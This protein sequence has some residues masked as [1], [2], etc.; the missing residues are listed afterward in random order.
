MPKRQEFE[1]DVEKL[2]SEQMT[3]FQFIQKWAPPAPPNEY[4][5]FDRARR[6]MQEAIDSIERDFEK[7]GVHLSAPCPSGLYINHQ[8]FEW[9]YIWTDDSIP[10]R[11]SLSE[12]NDKDL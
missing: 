4:I 12:V 7:E 9:D 10:S 2:L 1:K 5:V 11:L 3:A 6:A 8:F